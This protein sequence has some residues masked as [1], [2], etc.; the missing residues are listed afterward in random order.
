MYSTFFCGHGDYCRIM[1]TKRGETMM[2]WGRAT[3][4][5]TRSDR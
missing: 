1:D 2:E 5:K 3:G 4:T